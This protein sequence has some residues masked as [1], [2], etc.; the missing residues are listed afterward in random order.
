MKESDIQRQVLDLLVGLR[1]ATCWRNNAGKVKV[2]GGWMQLSPRGSP[3]VVGFLLDG[4]GRAL[5]LEVKRP[6]ESR[7]ADQIIF[8]S[9]AVRAN[10][11]YGCVKSAQEAVDLV[12]KSWRAQS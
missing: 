12:R 10:V 8:A 2:S 3:D 4:S 9:G 6:G 5:C 1:L 11:V 7:T